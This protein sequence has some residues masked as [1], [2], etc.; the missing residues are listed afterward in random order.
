MAAEPGE[1]GAAGRKEV[2][3]RTAVTGAATAEEAMAAALVVAVA[4]VEEAK[5]VVRACNAGQASIAERV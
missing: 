1:M 3:V 5:A 4:T 2:M